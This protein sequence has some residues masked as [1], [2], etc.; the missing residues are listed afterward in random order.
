MSSSRVASWEARLNLD[1]RHQLR[2]EL[3]VEDRFW[4][5]FHAGAFVEGAAVEFGLG[6]ATGYRLLRRRFDELREGSSVASAAGTLVHLSRIAGPGVVRVGGALGT[7]TSRTVSSAECLVQALATLRSL[8]KA[9]V[10]V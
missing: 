7:T 6:R 5:A 9:A 2:V 1:G 4:S 3:S 10:R 8:L